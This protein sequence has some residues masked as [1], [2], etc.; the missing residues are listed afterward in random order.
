LEWAYLIGQYLLIAALV[1][2]F[3]MLNFQLS[4]SA[5]KMPGGQWFWVAAFFILPGLSHIVFTVLYFSTE[6]SE[7]GWRVAR[8]TLDNS[9]GVREWTHDEPG[10][11][12]TE[13]SVTPFGDTGPSPS[14]QPAVDDMTIPDK[15]RDAQI[16][17]L[18]EFG[19]WEKA[20]VLAIERLETARSKGRVNLVKVYETYIEL[21]RSHAPI[22]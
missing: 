19:Q 8:R 4:Q 14:G 5:G 13:I 22:R 18:I 2:G 7:E 17:Q 9:R 6:R 16:E 12:G 11:H 20:N 21:L 15:W 1:A 10:G 3:V